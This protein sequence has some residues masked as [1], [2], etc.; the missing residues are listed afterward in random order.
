MSNI[1][2][3]ILGAIVFV[4]S[5]L[6]GLASAKEAYGPLALVL[7]IGAALC[8]AVGYCLLTCERPRRKTTLS[9]RIR[10]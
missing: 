2:I 8:F 4:L 7:L 1:L 10:P 6:L 9:R 3:R 5:G